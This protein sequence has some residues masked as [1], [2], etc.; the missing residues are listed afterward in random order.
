MK[1]NFIDSIYRFT[2]KS[3]NDNVF[4]LVP[5]AKV[6]NH[7]SVL[8]PVFEE[9]TQIKVIGP[10]QSIEGVTTYLFYQKQPDN[11]S[12]VRQLILNIPEGSKFGHGRFKSDVNDAVLAQITDGEFEIIIIDD[13][14]EYT[15]QFY[16]W[17]KDGKFDKEIAELL[18]HIPD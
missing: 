3:L 11:A 7:F 14:R 8:N 9:V 12:I 17:L 18:S 1:K 5:L 15:L 13:A 16:H 6:G 10:L 2:M 4:E